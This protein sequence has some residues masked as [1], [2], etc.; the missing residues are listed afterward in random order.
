MVLNNLSTRAGEQLLET[1]GMLQLEASSTSGQ[2]CALREGVQLLLRMPTS[3]PQPDM[4]LFKGIKTTS[5]EQLDWQAPRPQAVVGLMEST[6]IQPPKF[7]GGSGVL[8]QQLRKGIDYAPSLRRQLKAMRPSK[9]NRRELRRLSRNLGQPVLAVMHVR[10]TIAENGQVLTPE[11]QGG[12]YSSDLQAEVLSAVRALPRWS[13]ARWL[14]VATPSTCTI[15]VRFTANGKILV[16]DYY[17]KLEAIRQLKAADFV[18][19]FERQFTGSTLSQASTGGISNYLFSAAQLGWINCDR[20]IN[21]SE[22][23]ITFAV[24]EDDADTDIKLVF[25][26]KRSVL[27][28]ERV[29]FQTRFRSVPQ[30]EPA[31]IIAIK[32]RNGTT[33]LASLETILSDRTEENLAFRPV[34]MVEL[35]EEIARLE[36]K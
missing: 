33:Y 23:L 10:I 35:K 17:D 22:P 27:A 26:N 18:Q 31:T 15:T 32:Q 14:G 28:G 20:F 7:V 13:P 36:K 11:A 16:D 12:V 21:S 4:Q 9:P 5:S 34:S 1:G 30:N 6:D 29:G 2:I 24:S 8:R 25:K 3:R 19:A